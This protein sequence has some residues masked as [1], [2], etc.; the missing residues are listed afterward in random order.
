[1]GALGFTRVAK[2][3]SLVPRGGAW[4]R[5]DPAL[6]NTP[7]REVL[8]IHVGVENPF[9]PADRRAHAALL[10][11]DGADLDGLADR[12]RDRGYDVEQDA[13]LPGYRRFYTHDPH[14][15]R[16]EILAAE[17]PPTVPGGA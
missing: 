15:N 1:M 12:L 9:V 8:D 13:L 4:F 7:G 14:G 17:P 6:D 10:L 11:A 16:I 3:D 2:P 5:A